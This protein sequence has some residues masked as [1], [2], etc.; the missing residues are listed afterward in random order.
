MYSYFILFSSAQH[1]T[2]I[3][4]NN[5]LSR[6]VILPWILF[7]VKGFN[8]SHTIL[9]PKEDCLGKRN[10][11]GET[12]FLFFFLFQQRQCCIQVWFVQSTISSHTSFLQ[13]LRQTIK[14]FWIFYMDLMEK[15]SHSFA[16]IFFFLLLDHLQGQWGA[17][18]GKWIKIHS[19]VLNFVF[20]ICQQTQQN[21]RSMGLT[22]SIPIDGRYS[23]FKK[24]KRTLMWMNWFNKTK[25]ESN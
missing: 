16:T 4:L 21:F 19:L 20:R 14:N 12:S 9:M 3:V 18:G 2:V 25:S 8:V 17:E 5:G 1:Q 13:P 24:C 11:T 23:H 22:L 7:F 6:G 10:W 15:N